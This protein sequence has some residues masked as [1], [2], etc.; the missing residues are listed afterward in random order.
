MVAAPRGQD[1][2][3]SS[4]VSGP[5]RGNVALRDVELGIGQSTVDIDGKNSDGSSHHR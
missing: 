1:D 4:V 2:L 5:Q 3:H